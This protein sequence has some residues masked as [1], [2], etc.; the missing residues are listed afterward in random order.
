M[1][2]GPVS[3]GFDKWWDLTAIDDALV[4][5][6]LAALARGLAHIEPIASDEGLRD[7]V[8]RNAMED[9]RGLP[10]I[11]EAWAVTLVRATGPGPWA[12]PM[13]RELE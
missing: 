3:E 9:P 2:L 11:M 8:L 7:A 4:A 12:P 13:A 6:F 1:R 5:D 10:P